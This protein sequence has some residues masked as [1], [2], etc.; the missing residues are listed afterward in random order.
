M[1]VE[2]GGQREIE[3]PG[4]GYEGAWAGGEEDGSKGGQGAPAGWHGAL[5]GVD[6]RERF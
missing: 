2:S 5:S 3:R 6:L 1:V 4:D